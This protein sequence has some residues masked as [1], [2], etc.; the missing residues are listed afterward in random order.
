MRESTDNEV[1]VG[2]ATIG[3]VQLSAVLAAQYVY[4]SKVKSVTSSPEA[5]TSAIW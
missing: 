4:P 3:I 1:K 2:I 5:E